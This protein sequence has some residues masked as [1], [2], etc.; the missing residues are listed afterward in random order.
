MCFSYCSR[1]S[2]KYL[3]T[4]LAIDSS[5]FPKYYYVRERSVH[6]DRQATSN[7]HCYC[8]EFIRAV[9]PSCMECVHSLLD[10]KVESSWKRVQNWDSGNFKS[11][12]E[13]WRTDYQKWRLITS[14]FAAGNKEPVTK[15]LSPFI[16][17]TRLSGSHL[18]KMDCVSIIPVFY[19]GIA[20]P[21]T[22]DS[23]WITYCCHY[24]L[25]SLLRWRP[26]CDFPYYSALTLS[27]ESHVWTSIVH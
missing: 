13:I 21:N 3:H 27:S 7:D 15:V 23:S 10:K 2:V 8:K 24:V 22:S 26:I 12:S 25:S 6:F 20:A 18:S 16:Q 11:S 17:N 19:A 5:C 14:G 4:T 9:S 1:T